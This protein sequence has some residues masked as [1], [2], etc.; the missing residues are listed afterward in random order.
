MPH[1]WT[2]I[3]HEAAVVAARLDGRVPGSL[4]HWAW[5]VL[6]VVVVAVLARVGAR[7]LAGLLQLCLVAAAVLVAWQML[8]LPGA[9]PAARIPP[10]CVLEGTCGTPTVRS[11]APAA[12]PAGRAVQLAAPASGRPAR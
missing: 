7:V 3:M 1:L 12:E 6:L 5:A 10:A 11:G 9:A 8:Q 2:R 4:P